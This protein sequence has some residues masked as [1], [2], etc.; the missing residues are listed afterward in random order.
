MD[1]DLD[2]YHAWRGGDRDSGSILVERYFEAIVRFFR[3][4]VSVSAADD[5]VQ[6][7]FLACVDANSQFRG[8]G[9]FKAY[10]FGIA[11][12]VLLS[13]FNGKHRHREAPDFAASSAVEL[14]AGPV[15]VA[16]RREDKRL[17]VEGL[18]RVPLEMQMTLELFYWEG[19]EISE[20]A[21]A[22]DI[23]PGTVKSRLHRGR[24]LLRRA[25]ER[26]PA[27]PA[28]LES[29]RA[30]VDQWTADVRAEMP[31]RP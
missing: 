24:E 4:K 3:M 8:D 14:Q 9:T 26:L 27:R 18:R 20:L 11:R 29:A 16:A 28:A 25:M 12:R 23:P 5:L 30:L 1:D 6:R 22:L 21:A 2:L 17:L 10:V 15:T 31:Q 13:H 19:L 7:T